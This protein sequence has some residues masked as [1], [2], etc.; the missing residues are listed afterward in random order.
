MPQP[1][2][3]Y[4]L[5]NHQAVL[6]NHLSSNISGWKNWKIR[7]HGP[8]CRL[9]IGCSMFFTRSWLPHEPGQ[10]CKCQG[11]CIHRPTS[12][13][14]GAHG[15]PS[16]CWALTCRPECQKPMV[17]GFDKGDR[18]SQKSYQGETHDFSIKSRMLLHPCS[19]VCGFIQLSISYFCRAA[20]VW[21]Q[22]CLPGLP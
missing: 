11:G 22:G 1:I 6:Y 17:V 8:S 14:L 20:S 4:S 18:M 13:N 3:A 12:C 7:L 19:S 10:A 21:S 9:D 16:N 5:G 15:H 2:L